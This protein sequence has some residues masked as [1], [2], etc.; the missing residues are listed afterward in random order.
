MS[1]YKIDLSQ[2][3]K[4]LAGDEIEGQGTYAQLI[5]NVLAGQK[6]NAIK[7]FDLATQFYKNG[8]VEVD[9]TDAKLVRG[10]VEKEDNNLT[11]LAKAP[12]L[13]VID[14]ALAEKI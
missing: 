5:A 10:I 4:N 2:P 9:E 3:I 14:A 8:F 11:V 7:L 13:R 12:I 6:E 1:K